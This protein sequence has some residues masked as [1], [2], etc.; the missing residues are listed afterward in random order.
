MRTQ[1]IYTHPNATIHLQDTPV[2][3]SLDWS[4]EFGKFDVRSTKAFN[5]FVVVDA[6][7][8]HVPKLTTISLAGNE[9]T[10]ASFPFLNEFVHLK[11]I[12]V[13]H[14][15]ILHSPW[16]SMDKLQH[17]ES[18]DMGSNRMRVESFGVSGQDKLTCGMLEI[19][20]KLR[21]F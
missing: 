16:M 13:S 6:L 21:V 17:V 1:D 7:L 12:N 10:N 14:N 2:S 20:R 15:V 4:Y 3:T 11:H 5:P 18:L 9:I 19:F 8:Q